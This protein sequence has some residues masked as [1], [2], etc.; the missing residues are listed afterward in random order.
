VSVQKEVRPPGVELVEVKPVILGGD[1]TDPANKA[2]VTRKQHFE[3]VRYW[4]RIISQLRSE[5]A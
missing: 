1:P 5:Q 2:F 4:N 3:L